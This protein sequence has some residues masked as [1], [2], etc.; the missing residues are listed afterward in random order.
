MSETTDVNMKHTVENVRT[1]SYE[2]GK[3]GSRHKVYYENKEELI[4]KIKDCIE[5]EK[6]LASMEAPTLL[7]FGFSGISPTFI[8]VPGI[9][10]LSPI[11]LMELSF[12][13]P[14]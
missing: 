8:V 7:L 11:F 2:F 10:G 9:C 1:D 12:L 6:F 14:S 4:Q 3:A 5:A 13:T